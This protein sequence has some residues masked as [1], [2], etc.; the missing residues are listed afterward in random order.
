M[1]NLPTGTPSVSLKH[2]IHKLKISR[3]PPLSIVVIYKFV[4]LK[5][6]LFLQRQYNVLKVTKYKINWWAGEVGRGS[7]HLPYPTLP[8]LHFTPATYPATQES[9]SSIGGFINTDLV[10]YYLPNYLP[11]YLIQ[12]GQSPNYLQIYTPI[13]KSLFGLF[14]A[15]RNVSFGLGSHAKGRT[16]TGGIGKGR[17]PKTWK[18]L[19]YPL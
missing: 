11:L 17:K 10:I 7:Q 2:Q 6:E 3:D 16:Y 12:L 15:S 1:H 19:M 18:C 5:Q 13:L 9:W 4:S 8:H 14:P